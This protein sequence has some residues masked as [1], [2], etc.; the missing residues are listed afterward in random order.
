MYYYCNCVNSWCIITRQWNSIQFIILSPLMSVK[1]RTNQD[2]VIIIV[3][4]K[5]TFIWNYWSL[6]L[7][8]MI[9]LWILKSYY[10]NIMFRP[11]FT[12]HN[13]SLC[14]ITNHL[15]ILVLEYCDSVRSVTLEYLW[16]T[17][18]KIRMTQ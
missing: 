7:I 3:F 14:V 10:C 11:M 15:C 18:P 13:K 9:S 16:P 4:K 5:I 1:T 17:L 12:V 8:I 6:S 2:V